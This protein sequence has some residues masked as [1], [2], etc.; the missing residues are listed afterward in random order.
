MPFTCTEM[1]SKIYYLL[2]I[3]FLT[4]CSDSDGNASGDNKTDL[5]DTLSIHSALPQTVKSPTNNPSSPSKIELGRL[6]FYDP[7][8]LEIR[9]L[10]VCHVIIQTRGMQSI[11]ICH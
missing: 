3:V 8:Y 4:Q 10:P 7:F 11:E 6:L 2:L 1:T 9:T 5:K